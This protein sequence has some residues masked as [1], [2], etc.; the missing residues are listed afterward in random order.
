ME[1]KRSEPSL[2]P[3]TSTRSPA[4]MSNSPRPRYFISREDGTI[5]PLIAVDELPPSLHI[6]GVPAK[7]SPAKTCNM[8]S[9]GVEKHSQAC[10]A[11]LMNDAPCSSTSGIRPLGTAAT[12]ADTNVSSEKSLKNRSSEKH[13]ESLHNDV[14]DNGKQAKVEGIESWRHGVNGIDKTQVIYS[15]KTF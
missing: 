2:T 9:L 12:E 11:T 15:L 8:I 4:T 7:I 13:S 1:A 10:Y 3:P 14:F 6:V 5:T